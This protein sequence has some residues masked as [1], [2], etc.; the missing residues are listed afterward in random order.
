MSD[1]A[2]K[3]FG[4]SFSSTALLKELYLSEIDNEVSSVI[5]SI[6]TNNPFE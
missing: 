2:K 5:K 3:K 4:V 6:E 1:W